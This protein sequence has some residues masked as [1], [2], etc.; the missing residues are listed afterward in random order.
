MCGPRD[1]FFDQRE[2]PRSFPR[3]RANLEKEAEELFPGLAA[4]VFNDPIMN[5]LGM[6]LDVIYNL[7]KKLNAGVHQTYW[8]RRARS[9]WMEIREDMDPWLNVKAQARWQVEREA[10]LTVGAFVRPGE[11]FWESKVQMIAR[12][13]GWRMD[14]ECRTPWR[15][16]EALRNAIQDGLWQFPNH[17]A[18]H[19]TQYILP[20][21]SIG[22]LTN[23]TWH[24]GFCIS[25]MCAF[26]VSATGV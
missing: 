26:A 21:G 2:A 7:K 25:L 1:A 12:T 14:G 16:A 19:I 11:E 10:L 18:L 8:I 5:E 3:T 6:T 17:L 20:P 22:I 23:T 24:P 9:Y 15:A 13:N 4:E